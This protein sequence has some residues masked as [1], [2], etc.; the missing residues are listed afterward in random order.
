MT[1]P[2]GVLTVLDSYLCERG[3]PGAMIVVD[4]GSRVVGANILTGTLC[5]VE[6]PNSGQ[7]LQ[8]SFWHN[9]LPMRYS[10]NVFGQRE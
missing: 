4:Y 7:L 6:L 9:S 2:C 8:R 5:A 10:V 3:V 1:R